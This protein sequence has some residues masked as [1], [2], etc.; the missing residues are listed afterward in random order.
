MSSRLDHPKQASEF[1]KDPKR[2]EWHDTALWGVRKRR[3]AAAGSVPEWETLR[4]TAQ[5]I[6]SD[7]ITNIDTH[8]EA[9]EAAA[10]AAGAIVHWAS[11]PEELNQ[12]V[13]GILKEHKAENIVKSKSML[14]E[15]CGLNDYL[16]DQG[17]DVIDTDLGE[18]LVQLRKEPPSH[19]VLP[20]VHLQLD[21]IADI[22]RESVEGEITDNTAPYLTEVARQDLRKRYSE[23]DVG[24][25]G[26]NFAVAETGTVVVCT[27]EGNADLGTT[28]PKVHIA[29]MGL[30]KLV[31]TFEDL[32]VFTRILARS[33]TG[34]AVTTYTSHF[35]GPREGG[36]LHI[37]IVD[38]GRSTMMHDEHHVNSLACIRCGACMNTC[39]VFRRSGGHS[40][41][42]TIPGPI[43]SIL[44]ANH[45]PDAAHS[46]PYACSL[47]GSCTAVC[48]VKIDLHDQL[49]HA[50]ETMVEQGHEAS[51]KRWGLAVFAYVAAR[52]KLFGFT[53]KCA[54]IAA[55]LTPTALQKIFIPGW[56][57]Y[58]AV[59]KLAPKSFKQQMKDRNDER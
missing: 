34:Q 39:P 40:Y 17:Y 22:F 28:M 30:E 26:V 15:E 41:N 14:T 23:A 21:E 4:E 50:R 18:R 48:P 25:S 56:A 46:L 1:L 45:E 9:F 38:N 16:H 10:T 47:C 7:V 59:P 12:T 42:Y 37:V 2:S 8:L 3:D 32:G 11:K 36:E 58:R 54:S 55:R 31:P 29:C 19:I 33:A 24:I 35:T 51:S 52:P 20:A 43:G 53:T 44:G 27:N 6:K 57:K 49:L 13:N 5:A